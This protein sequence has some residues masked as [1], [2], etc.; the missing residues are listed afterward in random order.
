MSNHLKMVV[1]CSTGLLLLFAWHFAT[2]FGVVGSPP[3]S[4]SELFIRFGIFIAAFL[5]SSVVSSVFI[6]RKDENAVL[7]DERE[8]QIER[9][10][11]R[12]GLTVVYAGIVCLMWF[13][14]TPL[15]PM[16]V[17]NALL[18]IVCISEAFKIIMGLKYLRGRV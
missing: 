8:E 1:Y 18:G 17:A 13:V 9:R 14:F 5:I 16:Q 7:P 6:A 11:E 15:E 2:V 4:R 3:Q 10:V 12:H